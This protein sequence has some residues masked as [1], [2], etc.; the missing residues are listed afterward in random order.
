MAREM[1]VRCDGALTVRVKDC[2][3]DH[4]DTRTFTIQ[5]DG[6]TWE[7]DLGGPHAAALLTIARRGRSVSGT[8]TDNRGLNRRVRGVPAAG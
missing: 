5:T 1:I 3:E 7:V 4:E 6:E 8:A 2:A